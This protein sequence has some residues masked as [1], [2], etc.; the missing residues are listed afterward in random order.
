[1]LQPA[2]S[3]RQRMLVGFMLGF[4]C[5]VLIGSVVSWWPSRADVK[6]ETTPATMAAPLKPRVVVLAPA[7]GIMLR[8]MGL[9]EYLVGRHAFDSWSDPALPIC[10]DQSGIDYETLIGLKPT[11]VVMQ[12][13]ERALPAQLVNVCERDKI[14]IINLELLQLDAIPRA[15]DRLSET[16]YHDLKRWSDAQPIERRLHFMDVSGH[17]RGKFDESFR[18]DAAL[19]AAGRVLLLH[20]SKP[21]TALGPGSYHHDLLLRLGGQS[22]TPTGA[23]YI[24]LDAEDILRLKPE[25][26]I[27][28]RPGAEGAAI[29]LLGELCKLDIPAIR[30]GRLMV[31]DDSD[32]L[33]PGTNMVRIADTMRG[34][35]Q[36]WAKP[37]REPVR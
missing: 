1:M 19:A 34:A 26:I 8:D 31:I 36:S 7:A 12:W 23:A 2:P 11:H 15:V 20:N 16:V 27:I 9:G 13:G 18:A 33:I 37:S 28:V 25:A 10:G 29:E 5:V 30:S 3:V 14:E 35:L 17:W 6:N 21:P 4:V 22:A 24:N 32:A